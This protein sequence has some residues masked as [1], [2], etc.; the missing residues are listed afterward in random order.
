MRTR[1]PRLPQFPQRQPPPPAVTL[2]TPLIRRRPRLPPHSQPAPHPRLL[3]NR[4]ANRQ[5]GP[6][7]RKASRRSFI[8]YKLGTNIYVVHV[9]ELVICI[10]RFFHFSVNSQTFSKTLKLLQLLRVVI[11]DMLSKSHECHHL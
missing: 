1:S 9:Y 8:V 5:A 2:A 3:P 7:N 6:V 4:Q 10:D 11:Y